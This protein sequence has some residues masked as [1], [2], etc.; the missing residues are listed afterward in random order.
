MIRN[1][2]Q[3][4]FDIQKL[5]QLLV[6]AQNACVLCDNKTA[7]NTELLCRVCSDDLDLFPLGFD[8]LMHSP[9]LARQIKTTY[10]DGLAVVS[11]YRWP[12]SQYIP[13]LKFYQGEIHAVW[14]GH[15]LSAQIAHQIWAKVDM[16]IPMPLHYVRQ[17][18]RGYNQAELIT[19]HINSNLVN[20]KVLKRKKYTKP[21]S[22]LNK[23]QRQNNIKMAFSCDQ[24][25][26]GK[27]VLLVDDVV[28]TGQTINEA[29]RVLKKA[30]AT[31]VYVAA[32][33][34][35]TLD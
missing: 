34:F 28:T 27:V 11:D 14:F 19:D 13:S 16:I 8:V 22:Q 20:T 31:A 26:T 6:P 5:F 10:I 25:L 32:V 24:D 18:F 21:Q 30:G 17:F 33:A 15:M 9:N 4:L 35:R 1:F 7:N 3:A 23:R 12:F 29:A 2:K